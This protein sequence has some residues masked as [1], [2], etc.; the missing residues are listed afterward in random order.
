MCNLL[1]AVSSICGTFSPKPFP[2]MPMHFALLSLARLTM[3]SRSS[4]ATENRG[5]MFALGMKSI[6]HGSKVVKVAVRLVLASTAS[7]PSMAPVSQTPRVTTT[8]SSLVAVTL[9][10]PSMRRYTPLY[11]SFSV[12]TFI[13]VMKDVNWDICPMRFLLLLSSLS[14]G[15]SSLSV[16]PVLS[17]RRGAMISSNRGKTSR[18]LENF[19][20][21]MLRRIEASKALAVAVLVV[22]FKR[23]ISPK[24][25]FLVKRFRVSSL[26]S[27]VSELL[28]LTHPS[29]TT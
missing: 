17:C 25:L 6:L 11:L 19:S 8:P 4:G 14:N 18:R 20:L 21:V 27:E 16:F 7:S 5:P 22:S 24:T 3:S 23:A 28:I 10:V 29:Q 12:T 13:P 1:S 26:P 9:T 2:S 15:G